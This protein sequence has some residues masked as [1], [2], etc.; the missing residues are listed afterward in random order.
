MFLTVAGLPLVLAAGVLIP[1]PSDPAPLV[2]AGV[3]MMLFG[4][5]LLAIGVVR[6]AQH[7][8][9]ATGV[10]VPAVGVMQQW[11]GEGRLPRN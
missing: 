7:V 10:T 1:A 4:A 8:D 3:L 2:W 9:R 11:S 5:W 6:W